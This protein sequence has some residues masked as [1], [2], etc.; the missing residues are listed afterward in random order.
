[1]NNSDELKRIG[2]MYAYDLSTNIILNTKSV[3]GGL[4]IEKLICGGFSETIRTIRM[5]TARVYYSD[6]H[7]ALLAR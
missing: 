7:A 2:D 6:G 5:C 3:A 4:E 1:M